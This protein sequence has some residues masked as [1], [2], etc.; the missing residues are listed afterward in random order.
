MNTE[1]LKSARKKSGK[2][3]KEVADLLGVGQSTYKNYECGLREPNGD[4]IVALA[5][6]FHVTT[7]YLLG[8]PT[9]QPPTDALERLFTE[10][11]F[12]ALEEELLRKYMELP[13][14]ARQAVVRFINDATAKALQRKNGTAPQK[15]LVIKRSLHKVSAGTGYDLNDS[16]AWETVTV[17]DTDD[18]RKADFL[19]EIEGDSMETTFHDGETVCVQQ[20]PCVEVGEIGVFWVDG[21]GYIKELGNGC[22][23]SHNSS[24]DPIPLQGT[25]NRCIGRV[26]GT[27]DVIDD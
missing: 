8:R 21:C 13:H 2:T 18:S 15:L 25:E 9:A 6:L 17:K 16:D 4:T 24:Y 23:I 7:D 10:K 12:S 20:T 11:S 14:E 22:L 1:N 26:L 19:L 3:Q 27:A 5:N